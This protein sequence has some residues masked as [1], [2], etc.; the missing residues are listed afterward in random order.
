MAER[1]RNVV[2]GLEDKMESDEKE[3]M[4]A[5]LSMDKDYAPAS[6]QI[7]GILKNMKDEMIKSI[8]A[9]KEA[10]DTAAKQFAELSAAKNKEIA[11]TTEAIESLTKRSGELAVS[12][13]QNKNA[14]EDAEEESADAT[15][16]LANLKKTCAEKEAVLVDITVL[17]VFSLENASHTDH[18]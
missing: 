8:G 9:A 17:N 15:E 18:S 10:E 11:A 4:A 1:L 16:F 3:A 12:I 14:A 6:G 5:F 7:V 13:V 2:S